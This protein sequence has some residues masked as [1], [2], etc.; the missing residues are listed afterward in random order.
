[1]IG[2]KS[3]AHAIF[4]ALAIAASP[5]AA[6]IVEVRLK[7]HTFKPGTISAKPGDTIVFHNDDPDLHSM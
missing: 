6:A 2:P 3:A 5:A 1:M 7:D 4:A